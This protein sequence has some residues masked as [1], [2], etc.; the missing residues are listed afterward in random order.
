MDE[1]MFFATGPTE[2]KTRNLE[3]NS[4][5][6]LTTGCN[7]FKQGLDI[8]LEGNAERM[9]DNSKVERLAAMFATKYEDYFGFSAGDGA[10]THSQGL[11]YVFEVAPVKAFSYRRAEV[12]G[13]TRY[14]F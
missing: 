2:R 14:R 4:H 13:A 9:I 11:A 7:N 3:R 6:I 12:G 8:V 1:S 10:F 5:C